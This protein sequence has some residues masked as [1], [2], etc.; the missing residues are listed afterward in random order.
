MGNNNE[1][2]ELVGEVMG[3]LVTPISPK[4]NTTLKMT[5]NRGRTTPEIRRK[6]INI[7]KLTK[8]ITKILRNLISFLN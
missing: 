1:G 4:V 5:V 8:A 6:K 2:R 7:K 3:V